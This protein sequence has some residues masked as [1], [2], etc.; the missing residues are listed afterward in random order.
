MATTATHAHHDPTLA[1]RLP[2]TSCRR[3]RRCS[4]CCSLVWLGRQPGQD[5]GR[6]LPPLPDR[7]H[8][9]GHLRPRRA[10]LLARLRHP[11]ADQLRPRR[12]LHARRDARRDDGR[13]A[14]ASPATPALV[15]WLDDPADARDRRWR[16]A[17]RSTPRSS[18]SPTGGLRHAPRLAPLITA[19]GMSFILQN[20]GLVWKGARP[21]S[22]RLD[23][24][25]R[26]GLHDR[27]R[28][29]HLGQADRRSCSRSRSSSL[30]MLARAADAAGEGDARDRPGPGRLRDDGHQRQPD[31]LLHVPARRRARR[32]R[33]GCSTPSTSRTSAS[34]GL[35]ARPDRVHGG[36][37]RRASATCPARCSAAL[38]IAHDRGVQQRPHLGTRRAATGRSRSSSRS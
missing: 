38:L 9:R 20:V 13:R 18:S 26:R 17:R 19:I 36:G 3:S 23:A 32:A 16:S 28:R 15:L 5:A 33:P 34:T 37:A 29:V 22:V 1:G 35:P 7:A 14:S 4:S 21:I 11:R 25:A 2:Q 30:L 27:R 8:E 12:R 6:L 31:D 10:R 24:P